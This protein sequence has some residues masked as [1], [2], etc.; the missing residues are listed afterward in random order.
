MGVRLVIAEKPSMG[1]AIAAGLGITGSGRECIKG[2]DVWVTWCVG[3]LIELAEPDAY[4]PQFKTWN[5]S[6]LPCLPEQ[7]KYEVVKQTKA[8]YQAVKALLDD[9]QVTEVVNAGDAGREGEL[10]FNLVYAQ[11]KCKK[12]VVRFWTASLTP[13]AVKKAWGEMKPGGHY[14]GLLDAARCRQ[15]SDWQIGING[16]RAQTL[17]MRAV[18]PGL[19]KHV[20]SIGRVQ[21]PVLGL[22]Y[23]R[24]MEIKNFK[25][26]N[27]WTVEGSFSAQA[28]NY[29]GKWFT[30]KGGKF[31]DQF[32]TE[33]DAKAVVARVKG[34]PG[35]VISF[36]QKDEKVQPE[37]LYDLSALQTEANRRFGFTAEHTLEVLQGLYDAQYVTY[38]RTGSRYLTEEDAAELPGKLRAVGRDL[39]AYAGFVDGADLGRKL[40]KRFVDPSK[41]EDHHAILP[42]EQPPKGALAVDEQKLYDLITR[43]AIAAFY[44]DMIQGKTEIVTEVTPED[45]FKTNGSIVKDPG[46]TKVDPKGRPVEEDG[47]GEAGEGEEEAGVLPPVKE[48]D[49]AITRDAKTKAGRTKPPKQFTEGDLLEAMGTAGKLVDDEELKAAMKDCGLGTPATRAN[50]IE[51]LVRRVYIERK[52]KTLL[53]T[54]KGIELIENLPSEVLKSPSLTGDWEAKLAKMARGEYRRDQFMSEITSFAKEMVS[55]MNGKCG[56]KSVGGGEPIGKAVCPGCGKEG[57]VTRWSETEISA[58]CGGC[59]KTWATNAQGES[60]GK[61]RACEKPWKV[62]KNGDKICDWCNTW[63][64]VKGGGA[65][66]A[67]SDFKPKVLMPCPKCKKGKIWHREWEGETYARCDNKADGCKVSYGTDAAGN[68]LGGTC[69]FCKGPVGLTKTTKSKVCAICGEFQEPKAG[70]NGSTPGAGAQTPPSN[71]PAPPPK[72][73]CPQCKGDLRSPWTKQEK[74]AYRCDPC[75]R[76]WDTDK[77]PTK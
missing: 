42:T 25:P 35:R 50:I 39:P 71:R 48:G 14:K 60:L 15:E 30:R 41:V 36:T 53:I 55:Q 47:A 27:F 16:T 1:R 29:L 33:D 19:A 56:G 70:G 74:Y 5:W 57:T 20:Y 45:R 40:S 77:P 52:R 72:A 44:P 69:K 23:N 43:R 58:K 64:T 11:A 34:K 73:K 49:E 68:P 4:G 65:N 67:P 75:N 61:C 24:H 10:I 3:H 7:Y 13:A 18:K 37:L 51:V 8:Q 2:K 9:P 59:G 63:Q 21:T 17:Y 6:S 28:G 22:I 26:R 76:W 32:D 46:W 66:G 12:P 31:I 38:P 54:E 62:V